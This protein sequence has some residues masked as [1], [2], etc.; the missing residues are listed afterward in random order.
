KVFT[1]KEIEDALAEPLTAA[2]N[3]V[4]HYIPHLA[5]KL[6]KQ[7]SHLIKTTIDLNSQLKTEK[8]VAD[9]IRA[10][11]LRH[12]KNAAVV[13]IDNK[14]HEVI[15]YLGSSDFTD[16]TDGGQVNGANAV[17]QPG[18]TLKPLLYAM[19]IDEGLLTLKTVITDVAI[20]YDGYAPENYDEKFNGY[21][22][23]EYALEHSLNIPAVKSLRMLGHERFITKLADC[24]F[25]QIQ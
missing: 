25:R 4:P 3:N 20:N 18:S 7:G 15:T 17:R 9:Y 5:Y 19:C 2:R 11:R 1:K 24:G 8:I 12:I 13:I 22:T 14:T 16:T 21:V 23:I 6:K 10:Q